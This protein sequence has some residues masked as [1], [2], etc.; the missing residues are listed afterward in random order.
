MMAIKVKEILK[1]L[2]D[3]GWYLYKQKGSHMQ[4]KHPTKQGKVTV[5]NHGMNEDIPIK[6]EKSIRNQAGI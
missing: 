5:S 6:T 2:K 3:D 1:E 4:L